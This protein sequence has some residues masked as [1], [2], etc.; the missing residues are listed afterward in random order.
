MGWVGDGLIN[1]EQPI[2]TGKYDY[3]GM[4]DCGNSVLGKGSNYTG[5]AN[6]IQWMGPDRPEFA[7]FSNTPGSIHTDSKIKVPLSSNERFIGLQWGPHALMPGG[8]ESITL[9]IG[10]ASRDPKTGF[11]VKPVIRLKDAP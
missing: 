2:D 5:V 3:A 6:F 11:P 1:Y 9:A 7:Y 10:M 4:Y 8:S